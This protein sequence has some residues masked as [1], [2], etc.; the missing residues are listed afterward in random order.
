MIKT[1]SFQLME[2]IIKK[3]SYEQLYSVEFY[4]EILKANFVFWGK[5]REMLVETQE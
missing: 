3:N 5:F 2:G 4:L 1:E